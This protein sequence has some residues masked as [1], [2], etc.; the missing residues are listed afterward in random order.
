MKLEMAVPAGDASIEK[1]DKPVESTTAIA[2]MSEPETEVIVGEPAEVKDEAV[3]A[4]EGSVEGETAKPEEK[5]AAPE[6]PEQLKSYM[7]SDGALDAQKLV[8]DLDQLHVPARFGHAVNQAIQE[9]PDVRRA[10]LKYR[11]DKGEQLPEQAL[12]ELE[13]LEAAA[14]PQTTEKAPTEDDVRRQYNELYAQGKMYEANQLLLKHSVEPQLE[15]VKNQTTEEAKKR[16]LASA[17]TEQAARDAA[18][19][20]EFHAAADKYSE[21][22]EKRADGGI[23]YKDKEF[24]KAFV[25]EDKLT[26]GRMP[27]DA[28]ITRTL[29]LMGRT[30]EKKVGKPQTTSAS[31]TTK[32]EPPKP[33]RLRLKMIDRVK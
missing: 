11:K 21:L 16:T 25:E 33:G 9:S 20:K 10:I 31:A 22:M 24:H 19:Q 14:K 13:R 7:D 5:A 1:G 32:V 28:L 29:K 18:T 15:S 26:G 6:V 23:N 30:I 4:T 2:A 17:A 27:V 3:E 8:A 12:A